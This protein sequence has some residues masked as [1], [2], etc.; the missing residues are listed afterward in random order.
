MEI[1]IDP[2]VVSQPTCNKRNGSTTLVMDEDLLRELEND[3]ARLA[4]AHEQVC[5]D[6]RGVNT[7]IRSTKLV[8]S[9][10]LP[11]MSQEHMLDSGCGIGPLSIIKKAGAHAANKHN[12]NN[13]NPKLDELKDIVSGDSTTRVEGT[14]DA[15]ASDSEDVFNVESEIGVDEQPLDLFD[16]PSRN[17]QAW[18]NDSFT[19][20][21]NPGI[22][23]KKVKS[24]LK[25]MKAH[26]YHLKC[27]LNDDEDKIENLEKSN[28]DQAKQIKNLVSQRK[29]LQSECATRNNKL[30]TLESNI[31]ILENINNSLITDIEQLGKDSDELERD[32]QETIQDL[33]IQRDVIKKR[34]KNYEPN[35]PDHDDLDYRLCDTFKESL[36][37]TAELNAVKSATAPTIWTHNSD[38][39]SQ[40][41]FSVDSLSSKLNS[42][43]LS[44]NKKDLRL[45]VRK[46]REG[47]HK[48][49]NGLTNRTVEERK[50]LVTT[51][52]Q[53]QRD[54]I[55]LETTL[56]RQDTQIQALKEDR[57]ELESTRKDLKSAR[58]AL[59]QK[60]KHWHSH[61]I[62]WK[63]EHETIKSRIETLEQELKTEKQSNAQ[64]MRQMNTK[65]KELLATI[66]RLESDKEDREKDSQIRDTNFQNLKT[67]H[68]GLVSISEG[69][70][71]KWRS[72]FKEVD[73]LKSK[74]TKTEDGRAA[75]EL[76]FRSEKEQHVAKQLRY[77]ELETRYMEKSRKCTTIESRLKEVSA[78]NQRLTGESGFFRSKVKMLESQLQSDE[79][80]L[81]KRRKEIQYLV[82]D[83]QEYKA[84]YHEYRG[85]WRKL[86]DHLE[87]AEDQDFNYEG[88]LNEIYQLILA[89]EE[90]REESRSRRRKTVSQNLNNEK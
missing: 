72:A 5:D 56:S 17:I 15:T 6:N 35:E 78:Q 10:A 22:Q 19:T 86:T 57:R 23:T 76:R 7:E 28:K 87:E 4:L 66:D 85:Y 81:E 37:L 38:F 14:S 65:H 46:T 55:D 52:Q 27:I 80:E 47:E 67:D 39:S 71:R 33:K 90:A 20:A 41:S 11:L 89:V 59:E 2:S 51:L 61:F 26:F 79:E 88:Q 16:V 32:R 60:E 1:S 63:P 40:D 36:K 74:I 45:E 43:R 84:R 70:E 82:E 12:A 18:S 34:L 53:L 73:E 25:I 58:A 30:A 50:A 13:G 64:L 42:S 8:S 54:K 48:D 83:V 9:I 69:L 21:D 62:Y 24:Q 29:G 75:L 68:E 49:G 3:V 77:T 44:L 31:A